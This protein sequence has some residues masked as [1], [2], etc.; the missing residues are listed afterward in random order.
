MQLRIYEQNEATNHIV[1][2]FL[3]NY[4]FYLNINSLPYALRLGCFPFKQ[5]PYHD[6]FVCHK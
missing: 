6:C 4:L 5:T 2:L 1:L 3:H